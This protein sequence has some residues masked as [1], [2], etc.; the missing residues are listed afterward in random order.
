MLSF[1]WKNG[2]LIELHAHYTQILHSNVNKAAPLM[3]HTV[4]LLVHH[5]IVANLVFNKTR[6]SR[7]TVSAA[8]FEITFFHV[9]KNSRNIIS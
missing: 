4:Y 9:R 6:T 7:K 2:W 1:A 8:A 5:F 3:S